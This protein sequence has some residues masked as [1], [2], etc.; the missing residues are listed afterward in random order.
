MPH[1]PAP[2]RSP[3]PRTRPARLT[4]WGRIAPTVADLA[5]PGRPDQ[6]PALLRGASAR[7]VIARGLGRS[8]NNAAQNDGGL[9]IQ[10]TGMNKIIALDPGSGLVTCEAGVSLEQ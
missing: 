1:L 3:A 10:T 4:G 2:A 8:Y 5:E 6:V 7:G 9:V